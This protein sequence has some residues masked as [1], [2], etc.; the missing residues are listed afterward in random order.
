MDG[1]P[2]GDRRLEHAAAGRGAARRLPRRWLA[3]SVRSCRRGGR[4]GT[5]SP[6]WRSGTPRR[7]RR[8]GG[9]GRWRASRRRPGCSATGGPR[10]TAPAGFPQS[11]SLELSASTTAGLQGLA[12]RHRLTL[13]TLVQGAWGLLLSRYSG[14]DDVVFGATVSGRPAELPGV[15]TMVGLFLNTV[16]VRLRVPCRRRPGRLAAAAAGRPAGAA[17]A[18]AHPAGGGAGLEPAAPGDGAVR[19]PA[20][21]GELPRRGGDLGARTMA[22]ELS[23]RRW[24]RP[25]TR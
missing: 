8:R 24:S 6:G 4:T 12:R 22:C 9:G 11:E 25:T 2:P 15:E 14:S 7:R 21:G 10:E 13:N 3:G 19:H 1:A 20:G 17:P 16:P 23:G 18:R 5:S